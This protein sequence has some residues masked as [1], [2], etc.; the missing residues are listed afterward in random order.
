MA[1]STS[2]RQA[3]VAQQQGSVCRWWRPESGKDQPMG[4]I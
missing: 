3:L 4:W 2:R 1:M